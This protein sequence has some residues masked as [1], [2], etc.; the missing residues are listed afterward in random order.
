MET[1]RLDRA[2]SLPPLYAKA[3]AGSILPGGGGDSLAPTRLELA[4]IRVEP[5]QLAA[6]ARVCGFSLRESLPPTYPHILGF[7]LQMALMTERSFPFGLLGLVHIENVIEQRRPVDMAAELAVRVHAENLREH[8]AG[9]AVDLVTE[10]ETEG[11]LAWS[12]RS[13]YLRPGGGEGKQREER[14]DPLAG[15]EQIALWTIPGD[16]G[17]RYAD[18]SGDRNPIHLHGLTAKP[19]GFPTAI[20]HG[21]WTLAQTLASL[22]GKLP[23]AFTVTARF[24]SPVRIPGKVALL[25][26]RTPSGCSLGLTSPDGQRRHLEV[27][28]KG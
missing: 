14:A 6:Y 24:R 8:P 21:M 2:P 11:A 17:R 23:D 20:A 25:S 28:L 13:T 12:E 27:I 10:L 4:G 5:E 3:A 16:I 7:P 26:T 19:F 22:D 15:A 1:R 9:R 18:V